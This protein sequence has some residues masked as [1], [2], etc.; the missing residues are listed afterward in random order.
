MTRRVTKIEQR[1]LSIPGFQS[2]LGSQYRETEWH[3]YLQNARTSIT[4]VVLE[5]RNLTSFIID[6]DVE[7]PIEP[8]KSSRV[9]NQAMSGTFSMSALNRIIPVSCGDQV[10]ADGNG[11]KMAEQVQSK[12]VD[13]Q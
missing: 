8:Y 5:K 7:R 13:G 11:I 2:F 6:V 12:H 4:P 10:H 3:Q 9:V 1:P